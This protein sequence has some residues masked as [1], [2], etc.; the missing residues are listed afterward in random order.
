[1]GLNVADKATKKTDL[2]VEAH[3]DSLSGKAEKAACMEYRS[4]RNNTF[5]TSLA[6]HASEQAN[7]LIGRR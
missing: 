6:S 5:M 1:M 4:P 3:P 2:V 7:P